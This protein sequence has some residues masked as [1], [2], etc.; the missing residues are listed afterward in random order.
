LV[1]HLA[2]NKQLLP[3]LLA[4]VWAFVIGRALFKPK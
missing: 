1:P 3:M 4:C 2:G